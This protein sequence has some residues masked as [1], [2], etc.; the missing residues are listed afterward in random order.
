MW[1]RIG[2]RYDELEKLKE[3]IGDDW[4]RWKEDQDANSDKSCAGFVCQLPGKNGIDFY[5]GR[6]AKTRAISET[7]PQEDCS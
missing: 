1:F 7:V 6:E 2:R 3:V 4:R 5:L